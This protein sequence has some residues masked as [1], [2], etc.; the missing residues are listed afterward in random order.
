MD[1]TSS[2]KFLIILLGSLVA[3]GPLSIDMYLPSLPLIAEQLNTTIGKTQNTITIFLL[4]FSI[5]MLVY[6]PLSDQF[7]RKKLL[8]LGM[9]I[10]IVATV[11]CYFSSQVEHLQ[12]F[13]FLQA[14]GGASASVLA[15]AIVRDVFSVQETPHILSVMHI[16]TMISTLIAPMLGAF[17]VEQFN[18][19]A[20]FLFLIF[21][22][23]VCLIWSARSIEHREPTAMQGGILHHYK[24]VLSSSEGI[25]FILCLGFSFAGMFA[26]I[27]A[28][29]F[30]FIEYYQLKPQHYAYIFALNIFSVI[31]FTS[32]NK[33]ALKKYTAYQLLAVFVG[34]ALLA[35]TYLAVLS[36]LNIHSLPALIIGLML[37]VGVSGSIGANSI[38]NLLKLFPQQAG[39]ASGIAVSSQFALGGLV[40]YIVSLVFHQDDPSSMGYAILMCAVISAASFI[41]LTKPKKNGLFQAQ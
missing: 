38:A 15:R 28:S 39:T 9:V 23:V 16:I 6:G 21:Y 12:G 37:F 1:T 33:R 34:I 2:K 26:Y 11:G 24:V 32:L 27:T 10:Y 22:A 40:S 25:G 18:W 31:I 17:L 30:V 5:G 19:Q 41:F 3:F 7:G 36:L 29:P 35:G 4:G 13:R 8:L 14:L 20:I